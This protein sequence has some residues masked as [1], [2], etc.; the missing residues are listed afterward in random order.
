M[1][2]LVNQP[3]TRTNRKVT[4]SATAAALIAPVSTL[5]AGAITAWVVPELE[6]F[7]ME[8]ELIFS[9]LLTAAVTWAAGYYTRE[10]AAA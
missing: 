3:T 9:L 10:R 8:L 1:T 6:E 7:H 4:A 5:A 2:K